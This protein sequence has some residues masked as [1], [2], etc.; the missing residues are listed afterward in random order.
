LGE[1]LLFLEN[2]ARE[3]ELYIENKQLA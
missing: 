2:S 1:E 3:L